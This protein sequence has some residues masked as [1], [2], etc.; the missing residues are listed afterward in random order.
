MGNNPISM[1][2]PDGGWAGGHGY[3]RGGASSAEYAR[4]T[5]NM[6]ISLWNVAKSLFNSIWYIGDTVDGLAAVTETLM[7][8]SGV[9][10]GVPGNPYLNTLLY[11]SW[12]YNSNTNGTLIGISNAIDNYGQRLSSKDPNVREVAFGEGV[13][14]IFA[15][16]GIGALSKLSSVRLLSKV[17][18]GTPA[19]GAGSATPLLEAGTMGGGNIALGVTEHLDDFAKSVGGSTWKSWGAKDFQPQFLQTINN[20]ANK[21][22]F[23]LNGVS[24]PW[25]AVSEGA[26]GFGVSRATSWELYQLYSNPAALQRTIFYQG[27]KVVPNPFD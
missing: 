25:G 10:G 16:E 11:D 8:A 26:K 22:H 12:G 24:S 14:G 15:G 4:F 5:K 2:D 17:R 3:G 27:G 9:F 13:F 18:V 7:A 1:V 23:N 6:G 20:P 21:I 19:I